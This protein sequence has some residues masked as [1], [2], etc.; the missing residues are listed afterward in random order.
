MELRYS[1]TV[2]S[3]ASEQDIMRVLDEADKRSPYLDVFSRSQ[4]C[5]RQVNIV[6]TKDH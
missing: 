6:T 2:D 3:D 5:I 1:V 4:K